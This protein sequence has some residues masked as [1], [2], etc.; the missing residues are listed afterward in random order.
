MVLQIKVPAGNVLQRTSSL[1]AMNQISDLGNCVNKNGTNGEGLSLGRCPMEEQRRP[2]CYPTTN[3]TGWSKSMRSFLILATSFWMRVMCYQRSKK[4]AR[5]IVG[6]QKSNHW[7][8][9]GYLQSVN[10]GIQTLQ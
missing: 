6:V 2:G 7:C 4:A 8:I 1:S 3:R 9:K 10:G 5:K